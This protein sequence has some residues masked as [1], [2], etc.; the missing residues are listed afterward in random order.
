MGAG[1][2]RVADLDALFAE[3]DRLG[4]LAS[5]ASQDL[6]SDF[7]LQYE[8]KV[9]ASLDPF[10]EAYFD[11]Q[12][13]LYREISRR[14]LNQAEGEKTHLDVDAHTAGCNPYNIHDVAYIA[15][16]AQVVQ[17]C[18]VVANLP[19][20]ATVLDLGCGWGLSSEMMAF[21]GAQVR[22]VDINP[23]FV[24]LVRKRA[25][26]LGLPIEV[27]R[28]DF[29]HYVDDREYDLVFFYECL[30]H[31]LRPWVTLNRIRPRVKPGGRLV[32]AGEPV[33]DRWWSHWGLRLDYE[34][35]FCM[36]R[37][38]WWESGWSAGFISDCFNRCGFALTM[39]PGLGLDGGPIGFATL[40]E[41]AGRVKPNLSLL[42]GIQAEVTRYKDQLEQFHREQARMKA[43]LSWRLAAPIR[44]VGRF[45]QRSRRA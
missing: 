42:R 22:A 37:Y 9:D 27:V 23:M 36:R 34:S 10:S 41:D 5:P 26:R 21:A 20:S 14:D 33:N 3:C 17:T 18:L 45:L 43:S 32:W 29:D 15:R 11:Q 35:V 4:G 28:S 39:I 12:V 30:H 38:G 2:V 8:T 25:T 16:H 7:Q 19:S 13:A 31:S 6:L 1:V 44:V 40:N 24:E